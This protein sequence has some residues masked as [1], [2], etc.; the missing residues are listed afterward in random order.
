MCSSGVFL[1][2]P[3]RGKVGMGGKPGMW[4]PAALT[5]TLTMV[6]RAFVLDNAGRRYRLLLS[7]EYGQVKRRNPLKK[8]V[9]G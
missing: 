6:D 5:P 9:T 3:W 2:P 8:R 7:M 4:A 1:L